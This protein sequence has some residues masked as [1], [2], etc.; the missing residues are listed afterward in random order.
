VQI[1]RF[2]NQ[3]PFDFPERPALEREV[4]TACARLSG[5][6]CEVT[7]RRGSAEGDPESVAVEVRAGERP[8]AFASLHPRDRAGDIVA[9]LKLFKLQ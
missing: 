7:L 8:L 4:R 1:V 9:R 6:P 3:L 2:E 5:A